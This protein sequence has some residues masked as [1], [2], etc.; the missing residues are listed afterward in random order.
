MSAA[1]RLIAHRGASAHAPEN[2][3][4]AF[5][6]A[7]ALGSEE[8]ELDVRFS[9]DGEVVVFHDHELQRKTAL[10]GPVRHY[11]AEV[12]EQVDLGPWFG[13]HT[14]TVNDF[15]Q[16][17][18]RATCIP[19]LDA[20]FERFGDRVR[21]FHVELKGWDDL[22]PL[23]VMRTIDAY[24]LRDRVTITSFSKRPLS[25]I[26]KLD[27]TVPITFLLRDAHDAVRG[28]EYRAAL[29]GRS[30]EEV[31]A[32]WTEEAK[33]AGFQWVGVRA[34]DLS[35]DTVSVAQSCGLEIR[36][37]GVGDEDDLRRAIELGAVGATVDWPERAQACLAARA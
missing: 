37:W 29:Q 20:I 26:R 30:V 16:F 34:A 13:G 23:A 14:S 21:R 17:G 7:V 11:P 5:E 32:W 22:L 2:T 19:R 1:F 8:V 4:A 12:L 28:R 9:G 15:A 35:A 31:Q 33:R 18:E 3:V 27:P 24:G 36:C 25:E 6:T 10:S